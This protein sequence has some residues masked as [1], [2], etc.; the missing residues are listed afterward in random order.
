MP[1]NNVI[2]TEWVKYTEQLKLEVA[3][4][5][6]DTLKDK[7]LQSMGPITDEQRRAFLKKL[8]WKNKKK[9]T[10]LWIEEEYH[11]IHPHGI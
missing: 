9:L 3:E 6:K 10:E 1:L 2:W 4:M 7:I 5:D 8:K 11:R